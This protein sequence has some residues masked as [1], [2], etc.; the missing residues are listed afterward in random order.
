MK[1]RTSGLH[2]ISTL[3]GL[4]IAGTTLIADK[5]Y[6]GQDFE[7]TLAATG[8]RLLRPARKGEPTRSSEQF[9]K[10][11]R[12]TVESV[13]RSFE[14]SGCL[15]VLVRPPNAASWRDRDRAATERRH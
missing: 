11:L 7:T 6:Y 3:H 14:T 10:P 9:F 5:N 12:Q 8:L 15:K 2:P 13:S 1:G 4:P